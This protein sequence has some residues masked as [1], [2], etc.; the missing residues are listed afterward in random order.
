MILRNVQV[1]FFMILSLHHYLYVSSFIG[2]HFSLCTIRKHTLIT[3]I[4]HVK[5]GDVNKQLK[6]NFDQTCLLERK[7]IEE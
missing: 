7:V 2:M 6:V 5:N 4:I 1:E 3:V